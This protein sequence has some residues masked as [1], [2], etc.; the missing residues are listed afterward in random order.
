MKVTESFY[1]GEPLGR[2]QQTLA[3]GTYNRAQLLL[4]HSGETSLFVPIR[5]MQYLAVLQAREF[6]FVDGLGS[7]VVEV[8]WRHFRP[9]ERNSLDAPVPFELVYFRPDSAEVVRRLHGEL[10]R[11]LDQL[12]SRQALQGTQP[13]QVIPFRRERT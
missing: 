1:M 7:R 9:G 4:A 8:A 12:A 13:G 3:A 5:S 11:A 2:Q 6:L 10:R